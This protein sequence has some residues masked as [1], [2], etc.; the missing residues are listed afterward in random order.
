MICAEGAG[1]RWTTQSAPVTGRSIQP[2]TGDRAKALS[3]PFVAYMSS[4]FANLWRSV[5]PMSRSLC[6]AHRPHGVKPRLNRQKII[7][8]TDAKMRIAIL[9]ALAAEAEFL[10]L[11]LEAG[12]HECHLIQSEHELYSTAL[13]CPFDLLI[14]GRKTEDMNLVA[15][16]TRIRINLPTGLPVLVCSDQEVAPDLLYLSTSGAADVLGLP[17]TPEG[18]I[19]QVA[20]ILGRTQPLERS[21][22]EESFGEYRFDQSGQGV[23][24]AGNF[25]GLTRKQYDFSLL[26]FRNM[27]RPVSISHIRQVVWNQKAAL[28]SRTIDSHASMIRSKLNLRPDNGY[29]LSSVYRYGYILEQVGELV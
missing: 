20:A 23:F 21:G 24:L 28:V 17:T 29:I 15:M 8:L 27:S 10:K 13:K 11:H 26:L 2:S 14:L 19:A 25:I 3:P 16:L 22:P 4:A 12:H 6:T 18:L 5:E 9:T 1:I 7:P